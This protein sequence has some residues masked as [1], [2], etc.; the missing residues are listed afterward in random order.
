MDRVGHVHPVVDRAIGV[1]MSTHCGCPRLSTMGWTGPPLFTLGGHV[2][3]IVDRV[4]HV[5]PIVNSG[6][7]VHPSAPRSTYMLLR[8][9]M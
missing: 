8:V 3:P 5:Y 6:G 1:H 4:G 2:P 7:H 9:C